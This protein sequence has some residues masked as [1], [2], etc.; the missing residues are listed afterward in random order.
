MLGL[1][2]IHCSSNAH[3]HNPTPALKVVLVKAVAATP[4][5][6]VH[7]LRPALATKVRGFG[8]LDAAGPSALRAGDRVVAYFEL[9][10]WTAP[11]DADGRHVLRVRYSLRLRDASGTVVW[12][13]GPIDATDAQ[14]VVRHDLFI[15]HL[16]RLPAT[17]PAGQYAMEFEGTDPATGATDVAT[18][19]FG[20]KAPRTP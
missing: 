9:G 17:L 11:V 10:D 1:P 16:V 15:T 13:D 14:R 3:T 12:T 4:P 6:A 5:P 2:R 20:L 18:V 7:V 8:D 19:R